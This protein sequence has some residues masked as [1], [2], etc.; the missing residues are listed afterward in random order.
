MNLCSKCYRDL[1]VFAEQAAS[2]KVVT[3]KILTFKSSTPEAITT[4]IVDLLPSP[5]PMRL[6]RLRRRRRLM[7][8]LR[9]R[10]RSDDLE[11]SNEVG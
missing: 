4:D 3:E 5:N 6:R 1:Q 7:K 11:P 10:R 2:V 8:G 9:H